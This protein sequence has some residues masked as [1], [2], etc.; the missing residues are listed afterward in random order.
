MDKELS[1]SETRR[2]C[3]HTRPVS[4]RSRLV[5]RRGVRRGDEGDGT[6]LTADAVVHQLSPTA[7]ALFDSL[8]GRPLFRIR[9]DLLD[10]DRTCRETLELLRHLRALDLVEDAR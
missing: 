9:P 8:D 3:R 1:V 6:V 10:D 5:A 2:R 4:L 7:A